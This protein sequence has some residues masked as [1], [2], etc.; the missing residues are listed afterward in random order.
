MRKRW[1]RLQFCVLALIRGRQCLAAAHNRNSRT[2]F[3]SSN[4][5]LHCL[6][7]GSV[8]F[9]APTGID[10]VGAGQYPKVSCRRKRLHTPEGETPNA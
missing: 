9:C 10:P 5:K 2:E 1:M 4:S 7:S 8:S 6:Q 3:S